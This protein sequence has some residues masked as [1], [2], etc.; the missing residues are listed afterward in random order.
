MQRKAGRPKAECGEEAPYAAQGQPLKQ[1]ER[2]KIICERTNSERAYRGAI[3][4]GS[5]ICSARPVGL[6]R[7]VGRKP[8]MQR[9]AGRPK[10]ECGVKIIKSTC[11]GSSLR[12]YITYYRVLKSLKKCQVNPYSKFF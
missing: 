5:P 8:H 12:V 10:A 7:N 2:M 11:C 9:K 1:N 3:K 6:K 4:E